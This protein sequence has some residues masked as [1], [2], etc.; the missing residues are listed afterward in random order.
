M[1]ALPDAVW[2]KEDVTACQHVAANAV[3]VFGLL[4]ALTA[5]RFRYSMAARRPE[6]DVPLCRK[7][8][9]NSRTYSENWSL[10]PGSVASM[11]CRIASIDSRSR[12]ESSGGTVLDADDWITSFWS[13]ADRVANAGMV[14]MYGK[15]SARA[16]SSGSDPT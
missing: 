1:V 6:R 9:M 14:M 12:V 8:A 3:L 2:G 5:I 13:I 4:A 7:A 10:K 11:R 15:R 16:G